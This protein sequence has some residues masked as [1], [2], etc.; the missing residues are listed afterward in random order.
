VIYVFAITEPPAPGLE[1]AAALEHAGLVAVCEEVA[2]APDAGVE[3]YLRHERVVEAAMAVRATLPARFGT[4]LADEAELRALLERRADRYRELLERVRGCVELS[5][6]AHGAE[7]PRHPPLDAFARAST[8][9]RGGAAYLVPAAD[10][11]AFAARVR[12]LQHEHPA[13]DLSCTGPWPPYSFV[14]S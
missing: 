4:T 11:E 7:L 12:A 10:V 6:R 2:C 5:V 13:A 8:A 14:G 9:T 3:A 1:E